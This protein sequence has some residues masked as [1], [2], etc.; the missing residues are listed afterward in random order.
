[1]QTLKVL[2][3]EDSRSDAELLLSGLARA[4]YCVRSETVQ[5]D[6][7]M[8]A[9]LRDKKWDLIISDYVLPAFSGLEALAV[10][11]QC[12]PDLPFIIV[13]GKIGEDVAVEALQAG[14][15][16]YLLKDRL[17]RLGA[18][19]QRAL[20]E[21]AVRR[22]QRQAEI[23]LRESEDRYR[24]LVETSPEGM[25]IFAEGTFAYVNP[26]A[27]NI[28]GAASPL[29]LISRKAIDLVHPEDQGR[30]S[31]QIEGTLRG[32]QESFVEHRFLRLNRNMVTVEMIARGISYHGHPAVQVICR[33]VT[34][35]KSLEEQRQLSHK[36]DAL[37]RMAAGVGR[38]FNNLLT[39]ILGYAGLVRS[40]FQPED[41]MFKDAEHIGIAAER[42]FALT[43]QLVALSR[44]Q[45]ISPI[46]VSLN[47]VLKQAGTLLQRWAGPHVEV[48]TRVEPALHLVKADPVQI[49]QILY[50]LASHAR[51]TMPTGGQLIIETSNLAIQE[52]D[53][54]PF[55]D[56]RAGDYVTLSFSDTGHG[57]TDRDRPHIFEPFYERPDAEAGEGLALATVYG[58]VKQHAGHVSC[59]S[60]I[61]KGSNFTIY[62][63]VLGGAGREI[64]TS[65]APIQKT[66]ETVLVVDDEEVLREMAGLV[67]QKHGYSVLTAAN[68]EDALAKAAEFGKPIQLLFTDVVMPR[69]SGPELAGRIRE[70]QP[71]IG[72]IFTSG[73]TENVFAGQGVPENSVFLPKPYTLHSLVS[74][75]REVIA[76]YESNHGCVENSSVRTPG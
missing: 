8:R 66:G 74:R 43:H 16:D 67:L 36:M 63:P 4:G 52:K 61:G 30:F 58:I 9:A 62:L 29:D 5:T 35:Q 65:T 22:R 17:T 47:T 27:L 28:Y 75:V 72:I 48:L 34:N 42:A 51:R 21:G 12:A 26:A 1:M 54:L 25:A 39:V 55:A 40:R 18:A 68:G 53:V 46:P 15:M 3:V 59:S 11:Q 23:H 31:D 70:K 69:M 19:V 73:F 56:F 24:R 71:H 38:D 44:T 2:I 37:A 14:A 64:E 76:G 45:V 7:T 41:P 13:S 50:H 20:Q 6:G 49:E 32:E 10:A 57:M 33:D 60:Q